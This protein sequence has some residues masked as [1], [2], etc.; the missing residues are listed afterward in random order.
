MTHREQDFEPGSQG[1]IDLV[2]YAL[3]LVQH[4]KWIVLT[5]VLSAAISIAIAFLLPPWY[6]STASIMPP[7]EQF[8]LSALSGGTSLLRNISGLQRLGGRSQSGAYNYLAILE[9]RTV[10]ESIVRTHDL[11]AVYEIADSSME[12]AIEALEG[13]V[14]IESEDEDYFTISVEDKDPVRA[15]AIANSFVGELNRR[16]LEM[17]SLEASKNREFI[18]SRVEETRSELRKAEDSLRLQQENAEVPFLPDASGAGLSAIAELYAEKAKKEIELAI[19]S[20]STGPENPLVQE[21]ALE[22]EELDRKT[23]TLPESGMEGLRRYR[24]VMIQQKILEFILPLHEQAKVEEKRDVPVVVV[25]DRAIAAERKF[26]PRRMVIVLVSVVVS[27]FLTLTGI[28]LNEVFRR[29][30]VYERLGSEITAWR[31]STGRE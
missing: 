27:V 10:K 28:L 7:K 16:S 2:E 23:R 17:G 3:L 18:G 13:H 6:R 24:E 4:W 8:S 20:R 15:A 14:T 12:K 19:A 9:S 22:V 30:G 29:R 21:L 31:R 1:R 26:R 25:L 11:I 5:G